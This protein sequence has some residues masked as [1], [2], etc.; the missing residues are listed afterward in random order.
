MWRH[1]RSSATRSGSRWLRRFIRRVRWAEQIV[2]GLKSSWGGAALLKKIQTVEGVKKALETAK[3]T[4]DTT[5]APLMG[6]TPQLTNIPSGFL[7]AEGGVAT[8]PI[9]GIFGEKGPEAL[10]PLEK[11]GGL[12]GGD[13]YYITVQ[14]TVA[15][16]KLPAIIVDALRRFNRTVG[17]IKVKTI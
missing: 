10:V 2:A 13:T 8:H 4:A 7:R 11:Y 1:C 5:T 12:G 16:E 15:D 14:A 3:T 17:P 9:A 6:L